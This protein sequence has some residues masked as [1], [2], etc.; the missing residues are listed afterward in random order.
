MREFVSIAAI[1]DSHATA[2]A[3]PPRESDESLTDYVT[4]VTATA[5]TPGRKAEVARCL[6]EAV[7]AASIADHTQTAHWLGQARQHLPTD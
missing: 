4:R 2:L 7:A 5:Q 1:F 3:L 6:G